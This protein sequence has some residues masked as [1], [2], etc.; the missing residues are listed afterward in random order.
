MRPRNSWLENNQREY[1]LFKKWYLIGCVGEKLFCT[2]RESLP[3]NPWANS[4]IHG[5]K[6]MRNWDNDRED[7][8]TINH[9]GLQKP[10]ICYL[11]SHHKTIYSSKERLSGFFTEF[12]VRKTQINIQNQSN[13]TPLFICFF[14]FKRGIIFMP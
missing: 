14:I 12:E 11:Y 1:Y 4:Y 10:Q 9:L 13:Y 6:D 7:M 3:W 5:W 2:R 8:I